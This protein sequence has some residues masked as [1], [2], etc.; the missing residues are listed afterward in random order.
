LEARGARVRLVRSTLALYAS[1]T[2]RLAGSIAFIFMLARLL[3][4]DEFAMYGVVTAIALAAPQAVQLWSFWAARAAARSSGDARILG[5]TGLLLTVAYTLALVPVYAGFSLL[6]SRV[7]GW[8]LSMLLAGYPYVALFTIMA[9]MRDLS[10]V[11]APEAFAKARIAF[12]VARLSMAAALVW[13]LGLGYLGAVASVT[14][15]LAAMTFYLA[16]VLNSNSLLSLSF[17]GRLARE[18]LSRWRIPL[19]HAIGEAAKQAPRPYSSLVTGNS[20]VVAYLNVGMASQL[21]LLQAA[22]MTVPAL[23][24]RT[25]TGP[26][27]KDLSISL[28]LFAIYAGL[29]ASLTMALA[30][31]LAAFFNPA[32][33]DAHWTIRLVVVYAVVLGAASIY[34]HVIYALDRSDVTGGDAKLMVKAAAAM[35]VAFTAA[36]TAAAPIL[37]ALRGNPATAAAALFAVLA[38]SAAALLAYYYRLTRRLLPHSIPARDILSALTAS[39]AAA[40]AASTFKGTGLAGLATG[41]AAGGAAYAIVILALSPTARA[42]ASKL[43]HQRSSSSSALASTR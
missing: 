38:G 1:L 6:E 30:R 2:F 16:A 28:A 23:Y 37:A 40:L 43:V 21:P 27:P 13:L 9:Y 10:A 18:W 42:L 11:V 15:A 39:A 41:A 33:I 36:Y 12:E 34:K 17:D 5:G 8:R 3:T 7:M 25:L 35:I 32:Y 14:L 26:K 4:V 31:E 24:A 20:L 22:S 29:V 19:L